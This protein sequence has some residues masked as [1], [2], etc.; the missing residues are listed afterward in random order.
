MRV[1]VG[2]AF[3]AESGIGQLRVILKP[4]GLMIGY[5]IGFSYPRKTYSVNSSPPDQHAAAVVQPFDRNTVRRLG[6][7]I[8]A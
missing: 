5:R 3:H 6:G 8:V 7:G 2:L 4:C 1:V